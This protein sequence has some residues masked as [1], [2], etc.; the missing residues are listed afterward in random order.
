[1]N[2]PTVFFSHS[3]KDKDMIIAIKTKLNAITGG[4][5]EI[6]LSS[7]G[8]SIPFGSNWVHKIEDGLNQAKIMF[9]FITPN[10]LTSNWIYFEAG[11]A[12]SKNIEVIPV[13]IG[14]DIA[15]LKA[16]LNLLQG[17]N[18]TSGDGLNNFITI[19]NKKFDYHFEEKFA[20]AD[21]DAINIFDNEVIDIDLIRIFDSANYDLLAQ[22][23]DVKGGT[24][25]HDIGK[26]FDY[27]MDYLREHNI[28]HTYDDSQGKKIVLA[29]G[30]KIV[31]TIVKKQDE[32]SSVRQS[33][34]DK[35][36]FSISLYNFKKSF[37]LFVK[38]AQLN[39][40]KDWIHLRF[41]LNS[42]YSY[43]TRQEH[44]AAVM[45]MYPEIFG[46]SENHVGGFSFINNDIR[47]SIYNSS[48]TSLKSPQYVLGVSFK[49]QN[50]TY[51][52]M[53]SFL[54]SLVNIEVI[55]NI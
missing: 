10:S 4:T 51:E 43:I 15:L 29:Y 19:I 6:F 38:L 7:D 12:Y 30:I 2:K 9:V 18:I 36:S 31:Y 50:I 25:T 34:F 37:Q 8:Q 41:S 27:I 11:F 40:E 3:S 24:F 22:Y 54:C 20:S 35:I 42:G 14:I 21:Y 17:F 33:E 48:G 52:N 49:P 13:G 47:F 53:C 45:S 39:D 55:H 28:S 46:F 44:L 26:F 23:R 32:K 16:P 5:L 1:M